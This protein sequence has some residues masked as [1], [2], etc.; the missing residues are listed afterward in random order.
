MFGSDILRVINRMPKCLK[1]ALNGFSPRFRLFMA[2]SRIQNMCEVR[3][4][5]AC[6]IGR[7]CDLSGDMLEPARTHIRSGQWAGG[8]FNARL[9]ERLGAIPRY[10]AV[11]FGLE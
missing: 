1:H 7:C 8:I 2:V 5:T 11:R 10:K 4:S 9:R 3:L 6:G